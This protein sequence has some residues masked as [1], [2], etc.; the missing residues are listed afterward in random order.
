L[1][2]LLRDLPPSSVYQLINLPKLVCIVSIHYA[3]AGLDDWLG[4][5]SPIMEQAAAPA[6]GFRGIANISLMRAGLEDY[7]P[8]ITVALRS[9]KVSGIQMASHGYLDVRL[10][11]LRG[12][13]ECRSV[14][15]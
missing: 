10:S 2:C 15:K 14:P 4:A 6:V 5:A 12:L 3:S 8:L 11:T 9:G 1:G 13:A 7:L